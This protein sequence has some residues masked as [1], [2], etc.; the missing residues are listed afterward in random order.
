MA[1][2]QKSGV[3]IEEYEKEQSKA[4]RAKEKRVAEAEKQAKAQAELDKVLDEIKEFV[5]AN[6]SN[7]DVLK[8]ILAKTKELGYSNPTVISD[9]EDAKTILAMTLK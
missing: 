1:E 4:D 5:V 8:P 6:K 9:I 2:Q 3:S 7:L